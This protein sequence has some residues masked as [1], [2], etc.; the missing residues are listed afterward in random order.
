MERLIKDHFF[1]F[2]RPGV[3]A[4]RNRQVTLLGIIIVYLKEEIPGL[5]LFEKEGVSNKFGRNIGDIL[6][7]EKRIDPAL[8]FVEAERVV[9]AVNAYRPLF[10]LGHKRNAA[11]NPDVHSSHEAKE[12]TNQ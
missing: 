11:F 2:P 6:R 5:V 4:G 12:Q 1:V 10:P 3:R 9:A 8:Q 7:P